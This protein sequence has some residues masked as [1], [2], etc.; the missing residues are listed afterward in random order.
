MI[1][2]MYT[3]KLLIIGDNLASFED[4]ASK[5]IFENESVLTVFQR[6]SRMFR[7]FGLYPDD[8]LLRKSKQFRKT[9]TTFQGT[10]RR[11]G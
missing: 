2:P 6:S 11:F 8:R 7:I 10:R 4:I 5:G 1:S 9:S 3:T